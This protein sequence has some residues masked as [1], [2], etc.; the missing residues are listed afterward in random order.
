[1]STFTGY[2]EKH[3]LG[4]SDVFFACWPKQTIYRL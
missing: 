2:E 4:N 1:M 3:V